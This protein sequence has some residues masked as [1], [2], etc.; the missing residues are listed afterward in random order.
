MNIRTK[1]WDSKLIARAGGMELRTKLGMK[2]IPSKTAVGSISP[3]FVDRY[4]FSPS[5]TVAA[6][7]GDNPSSL[8]GMK[9]NHGDVVVCCHGNINPKWL[10]I[11]MKYSTVTPPCIRLALGQVIQC[12]C[13]WMTLIHS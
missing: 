9:L 10:L 5:C 2:P 8:A 4:G 7:M 3:Y 11:I 12:L 13:G 6:F 1:E